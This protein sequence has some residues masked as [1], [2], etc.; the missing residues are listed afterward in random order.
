M[1]NARSLIFGTAILAMAFAGPGLLAAGQTP[2]APKNIQ[3]LKGLSLRDIRADMQTISR[4]L[5]VQC[6]F[7]HV[8]GNFASDDKPQKNT[9]RKMMTMVQDINQKYFSGEKSEAASDPI[10]GRVSC[11]TCHNGASSPKSAPPA[12]GM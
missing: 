11:Y 6:T 10:K 8:A 4:S 7:C 5:G 2:P 1:R 3:V 9:A 12:P